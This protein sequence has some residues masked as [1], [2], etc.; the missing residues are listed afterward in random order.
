MQDLDRPRP[1][2]PPA[3][4]EEAEEGLVVAIPLALAATVAAVLGARAA[5]VSSAASDM[6]QIAV[7]EEVKRS[8]ALAR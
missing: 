2:P 4:P 6:W 1:S 7:R 5:V 3:Q 8:A